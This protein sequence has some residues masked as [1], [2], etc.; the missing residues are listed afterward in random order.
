MEEKLADQIRNYCYTNYIIPARKNNQE[1][2]KIV[3]GQIHSEMNLKNRVPAVCSALQATKID[4]YTIEIT[5]TENIKHVHFYI[6]RGS[7]SDSVIK[8]TISNISFL[9]NNKKYY[10]KLYAISKYNI[11]LEPGYDN[12]T[13]IV[14]V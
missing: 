1:D 3:V 5:G 6:T 13:F 7:Y 8:E 4:D 12:R 2:I 10:L 11:K 9:I 14:R